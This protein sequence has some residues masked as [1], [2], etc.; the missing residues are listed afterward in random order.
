L[1]CAPAFPLYFVAADYIPVLLDDRRF[2]VFR[3][4]KPYTEAHTAC[5]S[6]SAMLATMRSQD[7]TDKLL[8]KTTSTG[9]NFLWM[10]LTNTLPPDWP[11]F[12][13]AT[14]NKAKWMWLSTTVAPEWDHW[15]AQANLPYDPEP[16]RWNNSEGQCA[17]I[18]GPDG[19]S[20][21]PKGFWNDR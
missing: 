16:S 11:V 10:G 14:T 9:A 17:E 18:W 21:R 3:T 4:A 8:A 15:A 13:P 19:D 20:S 7:E 12:N 6:E 1:T 5:L 2:M